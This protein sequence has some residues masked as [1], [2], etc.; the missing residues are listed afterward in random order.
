MGVC[1]CVCACA[2]CA[3]LELHAID[4]H[5]CTF[6]ITVCYIFCILKWCFIFVAIYSETCKYSGDG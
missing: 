6:I 5:I 1:V 4:L 3:L 2:C